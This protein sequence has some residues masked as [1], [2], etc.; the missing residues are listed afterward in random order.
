M[1]SRFTD[2]KTP[3]VL[4]SC[5]ERRIRKQRKRCSR[6]WNKENVAVL[7]DNDNDND[8]GAGGGAVA[9]A[10]ATAAATDGGAAAPSPWS[11]PPSLQKRHAGLNQ[12]ELKGIVIDY[13]SYTGSEDYKNDNKNEN[14]DT[15]S[16]QFDD[17][18]HALLVL[19]GTTNDRLPATLRSSKKLTR[20][21]FLRVVPPRSD[22]ERLVETNAAAAAPGDAGGG[23]ARAL[24]AEALW[25]EEAREGIREHNRY[26]SG[27]RKLFFVIYG[28]LGKGVIETL[29]TATPGWSD[30]EE[31]ADTLELIRRLRGLCKGSPVV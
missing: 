15:L 1:V 9:T 5:S 19:A 18:Y 30:V 12:Q 28:Q 8:N 29:R 20:E 10:A 22:T 2:E 14:D 27:L 7:N 16:R 11:P 3:G 31:T 4:S 24:L 17:F 25:L 26:A 6:N 23:A 13:C 21:D